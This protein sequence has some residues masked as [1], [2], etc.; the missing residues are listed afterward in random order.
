GHHFHLSC[1]LSYVTRSTHPSTFVVLCPC[2]RQ[3]ERYGVTSWAKTVE[4]WMRLAL[5]PKWC[6]LDLFLDEDDHREVEEMSTSTSSNFLS[7]LEEVDA[8]NEEV[9]TRKQKLVDASEKGEGEA[10]ASKRTLRLRRRTKHDKV[11]TVQTQ[12]VV[13]TIQR[14]TNDTAPRSDDGG[15]PRVAGEQQGRLRDDPAVDH[16]SDL[17]SRMQCC[18]ARPGRTTTTGPNT[19]GLMSCS[20]SSPHSYLQTGAGDPMFY[21]YNMMQQFIL[22]EEEDDERQ[23]N[24]GFGLGCDQQE[25]QQLPFGSGTE[26]PGIPVHPPLCPPGDLAALM[27]PEQMHLFHMQA[28][29]LRTGDLQGFPPVMLDDLQDH[30]RAFVEHQGNLLHEL[31][32]ACGA[33]HFHGREEHQG[34]GSRT[35]DERETSQSTREHQEMN[36][37]FFGSSSFRQDEAFL[38]E[39]GHVWLTPD[40]EEEVLRQMLAAEECNSRKTSSGSHRARGRRSGRRRQRCRREEQLAQE[41]LEEEGSAERRDGRPVGDGVGEKVSHSSSS[42]TQQ[43]SFAHGQERQ[44]LEAATIR[45]ALVSAAQEREEDRAS[46]AA[47]ANS[48]KLKLLLLSS[49]S[50]RT[51]FFSRSRHKQNENPSSTSKTE[52]QR[53]KTPSSRSRTSTSEPRFLYK[54]RQEVGCFNRLFGVTPEVI[55]VPLYFYHTEDD[56][57]IKEQSA[58]SKNDKIDVSSTSSS[59]TS[60]SSRSF[61][62]KK[63][64]CSLFTST[65]SPSSSTSQHDKRGGHHIK[66]TSASPSSRSKSQDNHKPCSLIFRGFPSGKEVLYESSCMPLAALSDCI[67]PLRI[68]P[69]NLPRGL[70]RAPHSPGRVMRHLYFALQT[71]YYARSGNGVPAP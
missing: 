41:V 14:P 37:G 15:D 64:I 67:I 32:Q 34:E 13:G 57:R 33:G 17:F 54:P 49:S 5:D 42:S 66:D 28:E 9:R 35:R 53:R 55:K 68:I 21:F 59:S 10:S 45:R 30:F 43:R 4:K 70:E 58:L 6:T 48:G 3:G 51:S 52:E 12:D 2:C 46:N 47:N 18:A 16:L 29:S 20:S 25:G 22:H 19:T 39:R 11:T 40:Q 63:M 26:V 65:S 50:K 36:Q 60:T 61:T 62:A 31:E 8:T 71:F 44:T 7:C 38:D 69:I 27:A 24:E 1:F 56:P 23:V